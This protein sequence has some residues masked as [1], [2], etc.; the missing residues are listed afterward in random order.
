MRISKLIVILIV[1]FVVL[2]GINIVSILLA[3]VANQRL[4]DAFEHRYQFVMAVRDLHLASDDLTNWA[5]VYIVTGSRQA[6]E[7]FWHE[8][9]EVRRNE[10]A[11]EVFHRLGAPA[12]ELELIQRAS[13]QSDAIVILQDESFA[14]RD[15]G[16]IDTAID[17]MFGTGY[18]QAVL[19]ISQILRELYE[20]VLIRT[21]EN[22]ESSHAMVAFFEYMVIVTSTVLGVFG[23][24]VVV[25][26]FRKIL[27][28]NKLIRLARDISDG[29]INVNRGKVSKD[30][31]G[32]L[33][34]SMYA[35]SDTLGRLQYVFD[36]LIN[37]S[38]AGKTHY[39]A[40]DP[41]MKGIYEEIMQQANSIT[42]DFEFTLDQF[43][44]PYVC[45]NYDMQVMHMNKAAKKLVG[46]EGLG[47]DEIV[48][49]HLNDV[50]G[51]NLAEHEAV[52]KAIKEQKVQQSEIQIVSSD[53]KHIDFDFSCA[54]YD[55]GGGNTGVTMLFTDITSIRDGQRRNEKR[56]AYR[57]ERSKTFIDTMVTSIENGN[58]DINF[59]PS[60]SDE[61][62]ADIA[63]R[64]DGIEDEMKKAMAILKG[65]VD[66]I[67][68]NLASIANGDLTSEIKREYAGDFA[69][70]K[71]SINNISG[72]LHKTMSG[73]N[74]ASEQVLTGAQQ[75][76]ASATDLANGAS[77]QASAVEELNATIDVI[78]QQTTQNADNAQEANS[79]SV[80]SSENAN[81]GNEAMKQMLDAMKKIKD[82]SND[83]SRIIKTIQ[84]IAFQ[85]NLLALNAAVEAAR[86][87]EH[88]RGFSV[89]AEEVR[90]LAARSQKAAQETTELIADSI[91]RVDVGGGIAESTAKTLD[92]IVAN[93]NEVLQKVNSI[94][95]SSREQAEAVGQVSVGLGQISS[96]VQSNSAVS[97]ETAAA[98]EEL[99]SQAELLRQLVS[100]FKL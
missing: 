86:A 92:V 54:T 39:R 30:E 2:A 19:L 28:I 71:D 16:D 60:M 82:S 98:S 29:K 94:S 14:A 34:E 52:Q 49:K 66:E 56:A 36:D 67:N 84:D 55:F 10:Q 9:Y 74:A 21:E 42:Y 87:G 35:I 13:D 97:E 100:Y 83:I 18:E 15:A 23:V 33:S 88:G 3:R 72:N 65:Y 1:G 31:I 78:N 69:T 6:Y 50:L 38:A 20:A 68:I 25:V 40:K 47:W 53:G 17:I 89:V 45:F 44:E 37:N 79:L 8:V 70:I 85:T 75:I 99:N 43:I 64:Q 57:S 32:E 59:P 5:R 24:V 22:V 62:T 12:N 93:A 41:S 11:V 61:V 27:P 77:Q 80:K 46:M 51:V 95:E 90:N 4:E 73:I 96:V 58:L 81:E 91:S 76:S 26:I 7:S 63:K 48:G